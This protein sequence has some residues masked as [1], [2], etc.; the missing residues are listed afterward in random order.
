MQIGLIEVEIPS[1]ILKVYPPC[2]HFENISNFYE[3]HARTMLDLLD[4]RV[5]ASFRRRRWNFS[6]SDCSSQVVPRPLKTLFSTVYYAFKFGQEVLLNLTFRTSFYI[7]F[8]SRPQFRSCNCFS[9][10]RS[11]FL[12]YKRPVEQQS[13]ICI[14]WFFISWLA[15]LFMALRE[16]GT[17]VEQHVWENICLRQCSIS[18]W[19]M[20]G[21]CGLFALCFPV[22]LLFRSS[23]TYKIS[24]AYRSFVSIFLSNSPNSSLLKTEKHQQEENA[25]APR[26]Y[27]SFHPGQ[28]TGNRKRQS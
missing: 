9:Y 28:K 17:E 13:D 23:R 16:T 14:K 10:I 15:N 12:L 19:A 3:D 25:L 21:K 24:Q 8:T 27:A 11:A 1:E 22:L 4:H 18:Y 6:S 20:V 2:W 5:W 26:K 7:S